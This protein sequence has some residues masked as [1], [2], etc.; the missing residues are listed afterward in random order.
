MAVIQEAWIEGVST[1]KVDDLVQAMGI[2]GISKSQV[3]ELCAG[4]DARVTSFPEHSIAGER[5][6]RSNSVAVGEG[7]IIAM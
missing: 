1:R 5:F 2:E 7:V 3:S 6:N 4:I